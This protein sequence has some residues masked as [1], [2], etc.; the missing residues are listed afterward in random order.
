M[1]VIH[2]LSEDFSENIEMLSIKG[3]INAVK[4]ILASIQR[5]PEL[6][7]YKNLFSEIEKLVNY[8]AIDIYNFYTQKQSNITLPSNEEEYTLIQFRDPT[9][10]K[11]IIVTVTRKGDGK[12]YY[13]SN[14][15]V[16]YG[17]PQLILN[18]VNKY[19]RTRNMYIDVY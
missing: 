18:V 12:I 10:G 16:N 6:S 14:L 5:I 8:I 19:C 13:S 2:F 15:L 1:Y 9:L 11:W 3:F 7:K 4:H 17:T